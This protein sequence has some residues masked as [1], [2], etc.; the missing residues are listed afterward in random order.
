MNAAHEP[1]HPGEILLEEFLGGQSWKAG[2]GI[3][4]RTAYELLDDIFSV[5]QASSQCTDLVSR[6]LV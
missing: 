4:R 3:S 5:L 1:I 2:Q 6:H